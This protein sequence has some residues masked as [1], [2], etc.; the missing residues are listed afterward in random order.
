MTQL[1][2]AMINVMQLR[3][4]SES[5]QQA[6]LNTIKQLAIYYKRS[7]DNISGQEAQNYIL[8]LAQ[9]KNLKWSTCNVAVSS[10]RF[11]YKNILNK[12]EENF[13]L[14]LSKK[15]KYLPYI[16]TK[17]EIKQLFNVTKNPKHHAI[18]M[19][20]YGAGLRVSEVAHLTVNDID[21]RSHVIC[22]HQGKGKKDRY[23]PLSAHLLT[24]LR[25]YWKIYKPTHWLFPGRD[26]EQPITRHAIQDAFSKVKKKTNI[27]EPVSIHSLRHAFATHLLESGMDI[28]YIKQLLGH[29]SVNTTLRYTHLSKQLISK[30]KSPLDSL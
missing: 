6:Y 4:L 17:D 20:V 28:I 13:Y 27:K 10:I 5:T 22:I 19:T 23:V 3:N 30:I 8:H 15:E 11:F 29:S 9:D 12:T 21:S 1:R 14:P 25:H 7:P 18:F 24:E 26:I 2:Q 16:L